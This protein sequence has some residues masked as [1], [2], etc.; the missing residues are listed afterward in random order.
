MNVYPT[1]RK[2]YI[3]LVDAARWR[4]AMLDE[5]ERLQ[6]E[7]EDLRTAD[8]THRVLI[9][10]E[11]EHTREIAPALDRLAES[12]ERAVRAWLQAY[13]WTECESATPIQAEAEARRLLADG[14][15]GEKP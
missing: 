5:I 15:L 10:K 1:E 7:L 13:A 9:A 12:D 6:A 8:A 11:R 2:E 3:A 4:Q 14:K